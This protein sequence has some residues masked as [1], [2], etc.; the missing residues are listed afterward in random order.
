MVNKEAIRL[1]KKFGLNAVLFIEEMINE[2]DK[3][4]CY[5]GYDND[6]GMWEERKKFWINVKNEIIKL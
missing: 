4:I 3:E 2:Y 6:W 5:C 1:K